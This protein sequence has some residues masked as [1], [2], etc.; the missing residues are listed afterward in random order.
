MCVH[1]CTCVHLCVHMCH[2]INVEVKG[3]FPGNGSPFQTYGF[4]RSNSGCQC[5]APFPA[6]ASCQCLHP[7]F[8]K[9]QV[10]FILFQ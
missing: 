3:K 7:S 2:F 8:L 6:D 4:R 5:Q 1:T 9:S 10:L